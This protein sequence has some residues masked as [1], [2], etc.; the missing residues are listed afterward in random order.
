MNFDSP[1][2]LLCDQK[3][4]LHDLV[5]SQEKSEADKLFEIARNTWIKNQNRNKT[6][7][8]T[9]ISTKPSAVDESEENDP[10]LQKN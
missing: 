4:V 9:S 6:A 10:L 3:S 1:Y 2:E 7:L 8:E 5:F